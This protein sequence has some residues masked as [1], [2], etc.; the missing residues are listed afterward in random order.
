MASSLLPGGG[1]EGDRFCSTYCMVACAVSTKGAPRPTFR[2]DGLEINSDACIEMSRDYYRPFISA[3][4]PGGFWF[5]QG[6]ASPR[7]CARTLASMR[8]LLKGKVSQN[9]PNSPDLCVLQFHVCSAGDALEDETKPKT[10]PECE[11]RGEIDFGAVKKAFLKRPRRLEKC[12]GQDGDRFEH[13][14][15]K[16]RGNC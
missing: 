12:A 7:K 4:R 8:H 11:S 3:I 15:Q 1:R 13:M 10:L 5:E 14:L 16:L 9:P 6:G 2:P